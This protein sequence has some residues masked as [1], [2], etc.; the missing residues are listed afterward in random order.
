M[1]NITTGERIRRNRIRI[2]WTQGDLGKKLRVSQVTVSNW[3][4]GKSPLRSDSKK[5]IFALLGISNERRSSTADDQPAPSFEAG[6]S[7]F[8]A[9]LNRTRLE[10]GMSVPELASASDVSSPQ[11][12]NIE[13]GRTPNPR[14]ETVARIAKALGKSLPQETR[15]ETKEEAT[16]EGVG[17]FVEFDPHDS[18]DWPDVPGIYVLYDISDRP[19]YVGQG[20]SIRTRIRDHEEKFWFKQPIVSAATYLKVPDTKLR[21]KIEKILI[22]FLKRNAVINKQHVER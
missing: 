21:E 5:K 9:W 8:G 3:E 18:D 16:V 7:P 22:R 20:S 1:G 2:G 10:S 11:L 6:P 13:S 17:E 15:A 12:Y 14:K 19:V 4:S